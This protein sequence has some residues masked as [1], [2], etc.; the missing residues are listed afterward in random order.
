MAEDRFSWNG[1]SIK[2]WLFKNKDSLKLIASGCFGLFLA[3]ANELPP[4]WK[5]LVGG[6]V[7]LASRW[8]MDA[9]DFWQ[10]P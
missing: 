9:L 1:Y 2:V 8:A 6:V 4:Q 3:L 7:M 5:A 10:S